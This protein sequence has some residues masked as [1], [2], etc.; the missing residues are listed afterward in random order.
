MSVMASMFHHP[1][2]LVQRRA[3]AMVSVTAMVSVI[4]MALA[5]ALASVFHH[6]ADLAQHTDTTSLRPEARPNHHYEPA[7]RT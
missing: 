1:A 6:P 3:M 2:D 5:M 7:M 4:A